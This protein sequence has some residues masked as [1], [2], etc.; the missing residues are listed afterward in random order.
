[1]CHR[2]I[3]MERLV[4]LEWTAFDVNTAGVVEGF[5]KQNACVW[6]RWVLIG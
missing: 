6:S 2:G 1:M 3:V 5:G 4:G